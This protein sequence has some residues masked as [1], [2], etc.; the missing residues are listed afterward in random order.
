MKVASAVVVKMLFAPIST[1]EAKKGY[2]LVVKERTP[3]PYIPP[4]LMQGIA[5][6]PSTTQCSVSDKK[7][8]QGLD[9]RLAVHINISPAVRQ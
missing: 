1:N 3:R 9:V 5:P 2:A 6:V 7:L 4:L 8:C